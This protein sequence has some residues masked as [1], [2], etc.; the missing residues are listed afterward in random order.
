MQ[1]NLDIENVATKKQE[2]FFVIERKTVLG[3]N[4][5][6]KCVISFRISADGGNFY[7]RRQH[8]PYNGRI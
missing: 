8:D 3:Y 2:L 6:G 5:V 4:K 7:F 1:K